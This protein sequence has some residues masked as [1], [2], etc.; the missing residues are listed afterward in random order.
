MIDFRYEM[1]TD[2]DTILK[3][4]TLKDTSSVDKEGYKRLLQNIQI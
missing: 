4:V 3:N 2:I 1:N